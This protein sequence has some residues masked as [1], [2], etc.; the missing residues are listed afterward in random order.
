MA[1]A[2][3]RSPAVPG[4]PIVPKKIVPAIVVALLP[5]AGAQ[6]AIITTYSNQASFV[7]ATP[8]GFDPTGMSAITTNAAAG[9]AI[10]AADTLYGAADGVWVRSG[11]DNVD[12]SFE[13]VRFSARPT[14]AASIHTFQN[15]TALITG[16]EYNIYN[17]INES[18]SIHFD[19][20]AL[21]FGFKAMDSTSMGVCVVTCGNSSFVV[22]L[23]DGA[24]SL[25]EYTFNPPFSNGSTG[26]FGVLSDMPFTR[27]TVAERTAHREPYD[28]EV[29]GEYRMVLAPDPIVD[30]DPVDEPDPVDDPDPIAVPAPGGA[31]LLLL[32][33]APLLARRVRA[34][35]H[36]R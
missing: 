31:A 36:G 13:H 27:I 33:F 9:A 20:G 7:A 30:P 35:R 24:T 18:H 26:Y 5:V 1:A 16:V 22:T 8:G 19:G 15:S 3:A 21:A 14:I 32:G 34:R 23:F 6:A 25:G 10:N 4:V 11:T 2:G 28:N 17:S 29:F 12:F